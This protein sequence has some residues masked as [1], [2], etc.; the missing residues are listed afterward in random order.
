MLQGACSCAR[1]AA[2]RSCCAVTATVAIATVAGGAGA[3]CATRLGA[4][5]HVDTN[6]LVGAGWPTPS[7][8]AAGAN[9]AVL[10]VMAAAAMV[11]CSTT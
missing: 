6:G 7:G 4:R 5:A 8:R 3:W 2:L 1:V 11:A 10:A 9:A